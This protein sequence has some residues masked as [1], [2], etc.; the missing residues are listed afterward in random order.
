[1]DKLVLCNM[2]LNFRKEY[3]MA[4]NGCCRHCNNIRETSLMLSKNLNMNK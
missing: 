2:C 4:S 3:E 1:M